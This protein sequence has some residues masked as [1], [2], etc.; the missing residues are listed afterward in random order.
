MFHMLGT[1]LLCTARLTL[2][3]CRVQLCGTEPNTNLCAC[4]PGNT[5]TLFLWQCAWVKD[6]EACSQLWCL[7]PPK[8]SK[9][10]I[11]MNSLACCGGL[12]VCGIW[13]AVTYTPAFLISNSTA[14]LQAVSVLLKRRNRTS[15]R[16]CCPTEWGACYLNLFLEV[17]ITRFLKMKPVDFTDEIWGRSKKRDT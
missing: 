14:G 7:L 8:H 12:A 4:C 5:T 9:F 1:Q 2:D 17:I 3:P 11:R 16:L 13:S 6:F 10:V 15:Q